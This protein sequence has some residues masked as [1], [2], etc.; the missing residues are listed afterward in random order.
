MPAFGRVLSME[1]I[2]LIARYLRSGNLTG[3]GAEEQ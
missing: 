1:D 3:L 2:D